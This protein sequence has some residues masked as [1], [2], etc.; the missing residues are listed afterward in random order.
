MNGS[1]R[2][3]TVGFGKK[4]T[5][6]AEIHR[7]REEVD[8]LRAALE[9]GGTQTEE[10]F[11]VF[12][13]Q[14]VRD[15]TAAAALIYE[16]QNYEYALKRLGFK[17]ERLGNGHITDETKALGERIF[18]TPG[19]QA[20]LAKLIETEI[21]PNI[22]GYVQQLNTVAFSDDRK[23]SL[24]AIQALARL[25]GLNKEKPAAAVDA[26]TVNLFLLGQKGATK[27]A[28]EG[29]P[30]ELNAADF[31]TH[32]PGEPERIFEVAEGEA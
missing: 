32:E 28:L 26:R 13:P 30:V 17:V 1:P 11:A 20:I 4:Q 6:I 31:L 9:I 16:R 10:T 8:R 21:E 23:L 24:G 29:G 5:L 7:L 3:A 14:E 25:G 22:G 19:V 15:Q 27:E 18:G 12:S 2:P